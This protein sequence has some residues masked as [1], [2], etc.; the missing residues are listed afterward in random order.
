MKHH[1]GYI[2]RDSTTSSSLLDI[3]DENTYYKTKLT[4]INNIIQMIKDGREPRRSII[5]EWREYR[6]NRRGYY[7]INVEMP[8]IQIATLI[9]NDAMTNTFALN[10][11]IPLYNLF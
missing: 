11:L 4:K 9:N 1:C 8:L 6:M 3:R 10:I 7:K 5:Q 2:E